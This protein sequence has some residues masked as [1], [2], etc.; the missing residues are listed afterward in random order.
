MSWFLVMLSFFSPLLAT[1]WLLQQGSE[2]KVGHH[3]W[4]FIQVKYQKNESEIFEKNG[5]NLTPFAFNAPTLQA[6]ETLT[7]ARFRLGLRG[8]LDDANKINYFLLTDFGLNG[9][10]APINQK[11]HQYLT[12]ASLTLKYLPLFIRFGKFKYP[13]SEEGHLSAFASEFIHFTTLSDQLMLERFTAHA[14]AKPSQGVGAFRDSGVELFGV[15]KNANHAF[16]Y[17]YMLGNGSGLA[18]ENLHDNHLTHYGYLSYEQIL[19][20]TKGYNQEGVKTYLWYQSGKRLLE[21]SQSKELYERIRYGIGATFVSENLRL[22]FEYMRGYGMIYNGAKDS[23]PTP[24]EESWVYSIAP[25]K[26]NRAEGYYLLTTYNIL[27]SLRLLGRFDSYERLRN[28]ETLYRK[29]TKFTTG[30]SYT[31]LKNHR[32]DFNYEANSIEAPKNPLATEVLEKIG[33]NFLL[34]Y[35]LVMR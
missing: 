22:G 4:G 3:P 35:T 18:H 19:G 25:K 16:T 17:A 21:T 28:N 33:S 12:D 27:S 7:L 30:L 20:T 14:M 2:E 24:Y 5:I 23:N 8:A 13:G 9:I 29:F 11:Q 34:Q 15:L 10:T 6:Q 31:P 26:E 1:N 32:I